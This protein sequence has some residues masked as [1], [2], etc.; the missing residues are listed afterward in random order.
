MNNTH[1]KKLLTIFL[2]L[3]LSVSML[4]AGVFAEAA[5]GSEE[6]DPMVVETVDQESDQE[7]A[8]V[9]EQPMDVDEDS[10]NTVDVVDE[11]EK[12]TGAGPSYDFEMNGE[13]WVIQGDASA[14]TEDEK[15]WD[16]MF[17]DS[18]FTDNWAEDLVMVARSQVGYKE[19]KKNFAV[20]ENN[21]RKGYTRYGAW[22]GEPY[23]DWSPLFVSFCLN[24]AN[25]D[26]PYY[27][28]GFDKW[29]TDLEKEEMFADADGYAP[30]SGDLVFFDNDKDGDVDAAGIVESYDEEKGV[31]EVIEGDY[32]DEVAEREVKTS[33]PTIAGYGILPEN[34]DASDKEEPK[35][36]ENA[37]R[38]LKKGEPTRGEGDDY[39]PDYD[40]NSPA[41]VYGYQRWGPNADPKDPRIIFKIVP[42][43]G[44][45]DEALAGETLSYEFDYTFKEIPNKGFNGYAKEM[46]L[47]DGYSENKITLELPAGLLLVGNASPQGVTN[48]PDDLD[49]TVPHTYT[50]TLPDAAS[51]SP[52]T[53]TFDVYVCNNATVNSIAKYPPFTATLHTE[54]N[55]LDYTDGNERPVG[56]YIQEVVATSDAIETSTPDQ[57]GVVKSVK[58]NYPKLEGNKAIFAWDVQVGLIDAESGKLITD[59]SK[60]NRYGRDAIDSIELTD[61]L[62]TVLKKTAAD[63][64]T[65]LSG[66]TLTISKGDASQPFTSGSKINLTGDLALDVSDKDN[67]ITTNGSSDTDYLV[68]APTLTEY[69]VTAEYDVTPDMIAKFYEDPYKLISNNKA[70]I[71]YTLVNVE[72]SFE[73]ETQ[74]VEEVLPLTVTKPAS[75]TIGKKLREYAPGNVVD[76]DDDDHY[77]PITFKLTSTDGPFNVYEYHQ[78]QTPQYVAIMTNVTTAE[79]VKGTKYY[80]APGHNYKVVEDLT[81]EQSGYMTLES[82]KLNG[83]QAVPASVSTS[84]EFNPS[85]GQDNTVVFTNKEVKGKIVIVK[86]DDTNAHSPIG[87][88]KFTVQRVKDADGNAVSEAPVTEEATTG[89]NGKV[90]VN[91]LAFGTYKVVENW[92]KDGYIMDPEPQYVDVLDGKT[93]QQVTKTFT[94]KVNGVKLTLTKYVAISESNPEKTTAKNNFTG[95]FTLLRSTDKTNWEP[96]SLD[97]DRVNSNGQITAVLPAFTSDRVPYWYKFV[98]TIPEGWYDPDGGGTATDG[99][100]TATAETAPITLTEK[101]NQGMDVAVNKSVK[102][103]NRK[104]VKAHIQKKF[105]SV[106]AD[107]KLAFDKDQTTKAT[108]Y[109]YVG[110]D[111]AHLTTVQA[112]FDIGG[113]T[114]STQPTWVDIYDLKLYEGSDRIHY[115]IKEDAFPGYTLDLDNITTG[116]HKKI[117]EDD[118][119]ELSISAEMSSTSS[120]TNDEQANQPNMTASFSNI[121]QKIPVRVKKFNYYTGEYV[122]GSEFTVYDANNNTVVS[123]TEVPSGGYTFKLTPGQVYTFTESHVPDNYYLKEYTDAGDTNVEI[124]V[125]TTGGK[126]TRGTIDLEGYTLSLSDLEKDLTVERR[127]YN[128]QDPRIRIVKKDKDNAA[129]SGAKFTVYKKVTVGSDTYYEAVTAVNAIDS[130]VDTNVRLPKGEYYI[131]EST[132]PSGYLDPDKHFSLYDKLDP[133]NYIEGHIGSA[134]GQKVTLKKVVVE[135]AESG[136]ALLDGSGTDN[137]CKFDFIN[138]KNKGSLKVLKKVYS[139]LAEG[140]EIVVKANGQE[141]KSEF[142]NSNGVAEF[143]DL[144]VYDEDGHLIQYTI[145]ERLSNTQLPVYYQFSDDQIATLSTTDVTTTDTSDDPLV[146]VNHTKINVDVRKV[147]RNTWDHVFTNID[148]PMEGATIG[149]FVKEGDNWVK[150]GDSKTTNGEGYASFT[151]LSRDEQYALVE[152]A[153]G[154][155]SYFPY[156]ADGSTYEEKWKFKYPPAGTASIPD[157]AMGNYNVRYVPSDLTKNPTADLEEFEFSIGDNLINANHWVQFDIT[158]WLDADTYTSGQTPIFGTE[159]N[160]TVAPKDTKYDNAVFKLYRF[161]MPGETGS[162]SFP[163]S[164]ITNAE[165][166]EIPWT[167]VGTYTSGT[168]YDENGKRQIG[169]FM[170]NVEQNVNDHYVYMLVETDP[171]PNGGVI[172]P[173]FQYTFWQA[174]GKSYTVSVPDLHSPYKPRQMSYK[175]DQVN[176]DDI[177]NAHPVGDGTGVIYLA[178]IRIA[179]WQAVLNTSTGQWEKKYNPLPNTEFEVRL[180]N[181]QGK[182]LATLTTGLDA[183]GDKPKAWAQSGTYQLII[184]NSNGTNTYSLKDYE[185]EKTI[186]SEDGLVVTPFV[187]EKDGV[188]Y[189]GFKIPVVLVETGCP[190]GYSY[191]IDGYEMYLCFFNLI[192]GPNGT[193]WVF[194][195]AFFA[196]DN[197]EPY[198]LATD[199]TQTAWYITNAENYDALQPGFFLGDNQ[200]IRRIVDYPI[201]N[202]FVTVHKYGYAPN[203]TTLANGGMTSAQLDEL[204]DVAINREPLPGVTMVLQHKNGDNWEFWDYKQNKSTASENNAQFVTTEGGSYIFPDGLEEGT[205]RI[206]ET[207]LPNNELSTIYD[208]ATGSGKA[209]IKDVY[210]MAYGKTN[211]HTYD[212]VFTVTKTSTSVTMYNPKKVDLTLIKKDLD[213]KA[214]ENTSFSLKY[215]TNGSI[216]GKTDTD[217]KVVFKYLTSRS[218]YWIVETKAG[219]SSKYLQQYLKSEDPSLQNLAVEN[220]GAAIG[221]TRSTKGNASD[222]DTVISAMTPSKLISGSANLELIIKNPKKVNIEITKV[223]DRTPAGAITS[224][225]AKFA[226][227]YHP[228]TQDGNAFKFK[229]TFSTS[230]S[231][232]N[233]LNLAGF[234]PFTESNNIYETDNGKLSLTDL[235]PGIYA[236]IESEA[237]SGYDKLKTSDGKD[238]IYFVIVKGGLD[239]TVTGLAESVDTWAG[240]VDT[241]IDDEDIEVDAD[242]NETAVF[243]AKNYQQVKIDAV[244]E[245]V[246]P[247]GATSDSWKIFKDWEVRLDLYAAD[248]TTVLGYAAISSANNRKVEFIKENGAPVKLSKGETYYVKEVVIAPKV[249]ERPVGFDLV[250]MFAGNAS[251]TPD[252][253]GFYK[254]EKVSNDITVTAKNKFLWGQVKF[255]K[256]DAADKNFD[257]PL[258]GAEFEVRY[259]KNAGIDGA[260]EDWVKVPDSSVDCVKIDGKWTYVADIPRISET[261]TTYRIYETKAPAGHLLDPTLNLEVEVPQRNDKDELINVIDYSDPAFDKYLI[262]NEGNELTITKYDNL[263][264]ADSDTVGKDDASFTVYHRTSADPEKWEVAQTQTGTNAQGKVTYLTTPGQVYAIAETAHADKF[265]DLDGVYRVTNEGEEELT[266][267]TITVNGTEVSAYVVVSSN[268]SEDIVIKAYNKP[269]IKPMIVKQDVGGYPQN[270]V[271]IAFFKIYEISSSFEVNDASVEE[272]ASSGTPVYTGFTKAQN[273]YEGEGG[274]TFG[275]WDKA[276][277]GQAWDPTKRYVIVETRVE[278]GTEDNYN[279]LNKDDKRVVWYAEAPTVSDPDPDKPPVYILDNVYGDATAGIEKKTVTNTDTNDTLVAADTDNAVVH[280]DKTVEHGINCNVDEVESLLTGKRKVIYTIE[281]TVTSHNQALDSFKVTDNG[282]TFTKKEADYDGGPQPS[283]SIDSVTIG[284]ATQDISNLDFDIAGKEVSAKITFTFTDDSTQAHTVLLTD[285]KVVTPIGVSEEKKVKKFEIEYFSDD[286]ISAT[287]DKYSLGYDFKP[288]E[289][290]VNATINKLEDSKDPDYP[291]NEV[292][293]FTNSATVDMTYSHWAEDGSGMESQPPVKETKYATINVR[294]LRMPKIAVSKFATDGNNQIQSINLGGVVIYKIGI[295][296][297]GDTDYVNP[298]VL[299][300]LPTGVTF[301]ETWNNGT[302]YRIDSTSLGNNEQFDVEIETRTGNVTQ[303]YVGEDGSLMGDAETAVIFKLKGKEGTKG[304]IKPGSTI[305]LYFQANISET[306]GMYEGTKIENDVFAS[307]AEKTYHTTDNPDG[308]GFTDAGGV[309][310]GTLKEE[311]QSLGNVAKTREGGLHEALGSY[312]ND[313]KPIEYVW[314]PAKAE[315]TY[316][317]AKSVTLRKAVWGDRDNGFEESKFFLA[318]STRTN[319]PDD[320]ATGT[321]PLDYADQTLTDNVTYNNMG[322]VG[323]TKWRL[324]V[325]NGSNTAYTRLTM[326]DILPKQKDGR[327]SSWESVWRKMLGVQ[328]GDT[329]ITEG[330]GSNTYTIF[331]YTGSME[332]VVD[333]YDDH[334][335]N[336]VTEGA[337]TKALKETGYWNDTDSISKPVYDRDNWKTLGE[338]TADANLDYTDIKAFIIVF[339]KG[340]VLKPNS[341]LVASYQTTVANM[342]DPDTFNNDYAFHNDNNVFRFN[343]KNSEDPL[344]SNQVSVTLMDKPVSIEGDL[345]IDEDWDG[346]QNKGNEQGQGTPTANGNRRDYSQYKIIQE[347][348][349]ATKYSITDLRH[350]QGT[351]EDDKV[352]PDDGIIGYGES[353]EHFRFEDLL[354]AAIGYKYETG[355]LWLESELYDEDNKELIVD[356][357]RT[358]E[359]ARYRL[360]VN[361]SNQELMNIFKLSPTGKN[362]YKS[363]HPDTVDTDPSIDNY[364]FDNNFYK[365]GSAYVTKPFFIRYSNNVDKTKDWGVQLFRDLE[366]TKQAL[367]NKNVKIKGVEF[368]IYGPYGDSSMPVGNSTVSERT[369]DVLSGDPLSF[370]LTDGV[371][372][373]VRK[374]GD[375]YFREKDDEE[376]DADTIKTTL[377]TGEDGTI[378]VSG[379]NWWKEYDIKETKTVDGYVIDGAVA[380]AVDSAGTQIVDRGDGVFTLMV[381]ST[382]KTSEMG[383]DQVIVKDPRPVKAT[384]KVKK[385]M[386]EESEPL[387]KETAFK[388]KLTATDVVEGGCYWEDTSTDPA[389]KHVV[390]DGTDGAA[391][392]IREK[393]IKLQR[394]Q[395]ASEIVSFDELHFIEAGTYTFT[396]EEA[397]G[398]DTDHYVY[399]NTKWTYEVVVS[400]DSNNKLVATPSYYK[401]TP[402]VLVT[403]PA[404]ANFENTYTPTPATAE[405]KVKKLLSGREWL[406]NDSFEFTITKIGD[407]PDFPAS[408][409]TVT[410]TKNDGPTYTKSFGEVELKSEK[411]YQWLVTET[412]YGE[413]VEG[414][415]YD[416]NKIVTIKVKDDGDGNLIAEVDSALIQTAKFENTYNASG[417]IELKGTKEFK[418]GSFTST[419]KNYKEFTFSV[420]P[421]DAF[422]NAIHPL[423]PLTIPERDRNEIV[424]IQDLK[425]SKIGLA[426]TSGAMVEDGVAK[427]NF[428]FKDADTGKFTKDKLEYV[429]AD[430]S[431]SA[432]GKVVDGHA[433]KTFEYVVVEDIPDTAVKKT[434]NGETFYYDSAADI[435][436]DPKVYPVTI[437]VTDKGDGTLDVKTS[438]NVVTYGF[439]NEKLYTKIRLTKKINSLVTGDTTGEEQLTNVTCVFKVTYLDPILTDAEGNRRKVSRT[440]SVQFDAT[441]VTAETATLDKIPLDAA[442]QVKEVYAADYEG[443]IETALARQEI[444]PDTNLPMW[445]ATFKNSR[446]GDVTGGSVINEMGKKGNGFVITNRRQRPVNNTQ[447]PDA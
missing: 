315:V 116:T 111:T 221:Y 48:N 159:V 363:D 170:T 197:D 78:N 422:E 270:I 253:N 307:T 44:L 352:L 268:D 326:G 162:V 41:S 355:T 242:G 89:D 198:T 237:P 93:E 205:Y 130:N 330:T 441:N 178:S 222:R 191:D 66:G 252:E 356:R 284:K 200:S 122:P 174:N 291:V 22:A 286:V 358:F 1:L 234:K 424:D 378:K 353:V 405:V 43:D 83:G 76:Y 206:Y 287:G 213:G 360:N 127:I 75:L 304:V 208:S 193:S 81:S 54:F 12:D 364:V 7:E 87:G 55:V 27:K 28:E 418:N 133:G 238:V 445:T 58:E 218:K 203:S 33:D 388:F 277:G 247:N 155:E 254:V 295:Q 250:A 279:T 264:G 99:G 285:Q 283:Y 375:K 123:S 88:A 188:I 108:L 415:T 340:V 115:L 443:N 332:D 164:G 20:S 212:R 125:Q 105:Y 51:N 313:I 217:G 333:E 240:S 282:I 318:M 342:L 436:Y 215:P 435:K 397:K 293:S 261:P 289:I 251:L 71:D 118:Y 256:Y 354:P 317:Y 327:S 60:Y 369:E 434:V 64:G 140:F 262:N 366:I 138:I 389:T 312:A 29:I 121:E 423:H 202:T 300:M 310:P 386:S 292:T 179:K 32:E 437:T 17:A 196:T 395:T 49:P 14:N 346:V 255:R 56:H 86:Q 385:V 433:T 61:T 19:S 260:Q 59:I 325:D 431:T 175:M 96:V 314:V 68:A 167:L 362:Y 53:F 231:T 158:K 151:G 275:T 258:D 421:A 365:D 177:L 432:G 149:L 402:P 344:T 391:Q 245:L 233:E 276:N 350:G 80:L 379:L 367:D 185:T 230:P 104:L 288:G 219:Y 36:E 85:A 226:A 413:T 411:T 329:L 439:V 25:V 372:H 440:V 427:F 120:M 92:V 220:T 429:L 209:K 407:A 101:N 394:G 438:D 236:F 410:I 290:T 9:P 144:P 165:G 243:S 161:V 409:R 371:Y 216:E 182:V 383:A 267:Q 119:I 129:V 399:D 152:L 30:R 408:T 70:K 305:Y 154:K 396:I 227:Y 239:A 249:G 412:H 297:K 166:N 150:V 72:N 187:T 225:K 137:I 361:L 113:G 266:P 377:V 132:V 24:Y 323:W 241:L 246:Y 349:T 183:T 430:I 392:T 232:T 359:P 194:N 336:V 131:H 126:E 15:T 13:K 82:I 380:T 302:G 5:N 46:P 45:P 38:S 334:G 335:I 147:F 21:D 148:Y 373:L 139:T 387:P 376:V 2:S 37:N 263:H 348:T 278:S 124:E 228:F 229:D 26:M 210:E 324:T 103:H 35:Q 106:G 447:P 339:D 180:N 163:N 67:M 171:G 63:T 31:I 199:G 195:D 343:F 112:N 257:N 298:V 320:P 47:Y 190:D 79:L 341:D 114:S 98:E 393:E 74:N 299:D 400:H 189:H 211:N 168:K 73:N 381:P 84:V 248:K 294:P 128:Y 146:V 10:N 428:K 404:Y 384:P 308:Y 265:L 176:K 160:K 39:P 169:E 425:D 311:A 446:K 69:T 172:N 102:M 319:V 134:S 403:E 398:E 136:V 416:S 347:L 296:N 214:L 8:P 357:L 117:G 274:G 322:T 52:G 235:D 273:T 110:N 370:S 184:N 419:D 4:P 42:K 100:G 157:S 192:E 316:N 382:E 40:P 156:N 390:S 23:A 18:E 97:T 50:F 328:N 90:T 345:W 272:L 207:S 173:N 109:K 181:K 91:D 259:N 368:E 77:G 142:T 306:A 107:G 420:Y 309:I 34:P 417:D 269:L 204:Q 201:H 414:I 303:H 331:Y 321:S 374:E 401:G 338:I 95:T 145:T 6:Q 11:A 94:N 426:T 186:T 301:D 16:A 442:V 57:W 143:T 224:G 141:V 351:S 244:K 223:D 3:M 271:P 444:D 281:P 135:N 62:G 65:T 337:L 280:K 406:T 153:S